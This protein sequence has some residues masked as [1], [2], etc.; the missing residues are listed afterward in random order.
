MT[1]H[2]RETKDGDIDWERF[3]TF[4]VP[5]GIS[6]AEWRKVIGNR[7]WRVI[8]GAIENYPCSTCRENGRKLLRGVHDLVNIHTGKKVY[9]R[10]SLEFLIGAVDEARKHIDEIPHVRHEAHGEVA[11]VH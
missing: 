2:I 1:G 8:H 9:D 10:K 4:E 5:E 3:Y 11:V 7:A 6:D